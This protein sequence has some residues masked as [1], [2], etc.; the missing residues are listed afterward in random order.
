[1]RRVVLLWP[2]IKICLVENKVTYLMEDKDITVLEE[3][4][5]LLEPFYESTLVLERDGSVISDILCEIVGLKEHLERWEK[6][7]QYKN[8]DTVAAQMLLKLDEMLE[9]Y[10]DCDFIIAA[11]ILDRTLGTNWKKIVPVEYQSRGMDFIKTEMSKLNPNWEK[12]S[13]DTTSSR[14]T[15]DQMHENIKSLGRGFKQTIEGSE[16]R[17]MKTE[18]EVYFETAL[19]EKGQPILEWWCDGKSVELMPNL[20]ILAKRLFSIPG[21]A[22]MSERTWSTVGHIWNPSRNRLLP[23]TVEMLTFLRS[24]CDMW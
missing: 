2:E 17:K 21:S 4:L 6:N 18:F 7:S 8:T 22:A 15:T 12:V 9:L 16:L 3:F 20:S 23:E 19:P 11:V 13:T 5:A 1:V 24:N 14:T 10:L